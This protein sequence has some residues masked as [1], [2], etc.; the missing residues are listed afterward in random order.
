MRYLVLF[1]IEL[2]LTTYCIVDVVQRPDDRPH[3]LP[4]IGWIL[5][6]LLFPIA[7]CLVWIYLRSREHPERRTERRSPAPDDDPEYLAWLREQERRRRQN[8][9]R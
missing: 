9:D 2:A 4:K 1:L 7:P 8:G 3:G 6:F 5:I